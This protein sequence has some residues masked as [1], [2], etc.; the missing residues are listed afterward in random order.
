MLFTSTEFLLE[1]LPIVFCGYWACTYVSQTAA[2]LWLVMASLIFYGYWNPLYLLLLVPSIAFNYAAGRLIVAL[3]GRRRA[4]TTA[5]AVA[6]NLGVL[7]YF[8]YTAFIVTNLDLLGLKLPLPSIVLPL[9]ISFITFQKIA[10][11]VDAYNGKT[12]DAGPVRFALFV[13]F[14]PQLIAGPISHH[15]EIVPQLRD[16]TVF[17]LKNVAVGLSLFAIGLAKKILIA[18]GVAAIADVGFGMVSRGEE[19]SFW[20][21][22][23][24]ALAYSMQLY[25]DFSGYSDMACGLALLFGIRLPIN[26]YSPYKASSIIE[27][28][29]RWHM[30]LSRFLRDY[31]YIPLGGSRRGSQY[32]NIL[33]T[34]VLGGL[35]HGAAWT[36]VIWGAF[37][38]LLLLINHGWRTLRGNAPE[39]GPGIVRFGC[40]ALTFAAVVFGWVLFRSE[41]VVAA[42]KMYQSMF[43]LHSAVSLGGTGPT[44]FQ[45]V[46]VIVA[47][48]AAFLLPNT[49]QIFA[50][51]QPM[52]ENSSLKAN[53]TW[54]SWRP[55]L[56]WAV[57]VACCLAAALLPVQPKLSFLYF[58]F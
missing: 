55:S 8:K 52:L 40:T 34:M 9:G 23:A 7:L 58:Q 33:I 6:A 56:A 14:F 3:S 49:Y 44:P 16:K 30:T 21:A 18:D 57:V 5:A 35:W 50:N 46:R 37:H 10:Y 47:L 15:S 25:F 31:L 11:V 22:W 42:G 17:Q 45:W 28:W 1:F 43:N 48:C 32:L 13:S 12:Y 39:T 27:F 2:T 19:I 54:L 24:A 26:F 38:G 51:Y 29:R 53:A 4:W 36:F 41:G 20:S